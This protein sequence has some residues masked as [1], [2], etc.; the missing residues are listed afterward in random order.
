L[1]DYDLNYLQIIFRDSLGR[2]RTN[3]T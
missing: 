3:E 1:H 2:Q